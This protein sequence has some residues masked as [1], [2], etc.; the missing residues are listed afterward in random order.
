[1]TDTLSPF[2]DATIVVSFP[3]LTIDVRLQADR[4]DIV[5]LVG[6]NGAGKST[7]LRVLAGLQPLHDG[8]VIIGSRVV[9]DPALGVLI[10]AAQRR[11]GVVFQDYRLF[12]HLTA[13]DNVAFGLRCHGMK[14]RAARA[15]AAEWLE[16][17]DITDHADHKPA[18]LSGGQA[19]RVALARALATVP[20]VLLLDEPLAAIDSD[21]RQRIREDLARYLDGFQG[22]TILVSHD[23]ADIQAIASRTVMLDKGIIVGS[24]SAS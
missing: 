12:A 11:V 7:V 15:A 23:Q 8:R 20:D 10:T 9:D 16:R 3:T 4:G 1:V 6:P 22:T 5:G 2:V 14:R 13:L 21:T 18:A 17:L 19:Q 24:I